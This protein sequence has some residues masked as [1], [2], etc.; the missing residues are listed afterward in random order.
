MIIREWRGRTT[1]ARSA[2]YPQHFRSFVVPEL[3]K[4]PG[5]LGAFLS[6]WL[7]GD[8]V[9]F[10]VLTRWTSMEAGRAFA[11]NDPEK[12]VVEPGAVSALTDFH[13]VV[14]H[15]EVL[16]AVSKRRRWRCAPPGQALLECGDLHF[17]CQHLR[18]AVPVDSWAGPQR[19]FKTD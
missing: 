19:D 3:R 11:G 12:A 8:Q 9:E 15:Y 14:R 18:R 2:E 17:A 1:R 13:R 16:E 10:L 6:Q 5:F 4:V 7:Y